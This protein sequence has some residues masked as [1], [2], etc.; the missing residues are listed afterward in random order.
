M[1][2]ILVQ[3]LIFGAAMSIGI[4]LFCCSAMNVPGFYRMAQNPGFA[5]GTVTGKYPENHR[6]VGYTFT[7]GNQSYSGEDAV[8]DAFDR[9][10]PGDKVRVTYDPKD[11]S[12][13]MLMGSA[14]DIY[15]QELLLSAIF[16]VIAGFPAGFTT[17]LLFRLIKE[18]LNHSR[19]A[20]NHI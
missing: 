16:G 15:K 3:C 17:F 12:T 10:K 9:T 4:M 14:S 2:R 20:A 1:K 6:H 18:H 5:E 19:E 11:P 13:S 7:V 8:G